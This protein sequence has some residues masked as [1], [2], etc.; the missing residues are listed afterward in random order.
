MNVMQIIALYRNQI[1]KN[2]SNRKSSH[3]VWKRAFSLEGIEKE[4]D[5]L[6]TDQAMWK[7]ESNFV[8]PVNRQH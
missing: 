1:S 4:T 8:E 2:I 7:N 5:S 3:T 6:S